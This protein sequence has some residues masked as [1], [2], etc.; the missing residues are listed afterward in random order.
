MKENQ[1]QKQK[2]LTRSLILEAA[3]VEFSRTGFIGSKTIDI[4]KAAGVSHGSIFSH[5]QTQ[6]E[7]VVATIRE[8]GERVN[9]RLHEMLNNEADLKDL[10]R[11]HIDGLKEFEAFYTHLI[12]ERRMLPKTITD[13]FIMIESTI[14]FHIG[15]AAEREMKMGSLKKVPVHLIFNSWVGLIHYYLTNSDLFCQ[16]GSVLDIYGEELLMYYLNQIKKEVK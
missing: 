14:S 5:F 8:F 6:E 9:L 16:E 10:L 3:I 11:S 7:L 2:N 13:T 15:I 12:I 4:A 1:R